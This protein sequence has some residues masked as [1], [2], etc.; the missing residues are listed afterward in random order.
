MIRRFWVLTLLLGVAGST[1]QLLSQRG[2]PP[3]PPAPRAAAI[4]LTGYWVSLVTED[5]RF[6]IVTPT[7]GD[8]ACALEPRGSQ[9]C[10]RLGSDKDEA[11]ASSAKPTEQAG[12]CGCPDDS[13][14][15][16]RMTTL[17]LEMDAGTQTRML[18]FGS[19]PREGGD[20]QGVSLASWDRA[21][22][23]GRDGWPRFFGAAA[24]A[25]AR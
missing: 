11:R 7:K 14:S 21:Q 4:D 17:K 22:C 24:H 6:R 8:Y 12:S 10:R 18:A 5:W 9:G 16:G 19:A 15:H 1:T 23:D 20:W 25:V 13:V 2:G 3:P